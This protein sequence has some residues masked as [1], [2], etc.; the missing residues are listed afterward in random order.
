MQL[1][2]KDDA[3]YERRGVAPPERISHEMTPEDIRDKV[4]DLH[5]RNWRAEGNRLFCDTDMG[6]LVQ[7]IPT[8]YIFSGM[9]KKG[10]PTFRQV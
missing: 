5:P 7:H 2:H 4:Q 1:T 8:D 9:D 10:L 3:W 6:T